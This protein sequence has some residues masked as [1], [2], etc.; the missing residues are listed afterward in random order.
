M[1]SAREPLGLTPRPVM[2]SP[3]TFPTEIWTVI[4]T[5]LCGHCRGLSGADP[6]D[7]YDVEAQTLASLSAASKRLQ[8]VAQPLLFHRLLRGFGKPNHFRHFIRALQL[9][10][11]LAFQIRQVDMSVHPW[12]Y[13]CEDDVAFFK[14]MATQLCLAEESDPGLGRADTEPKIA[15]IVRAEVF[16]SMIPQIE[17]LEVD[18]RKIWGRTPVWGG[19]EFDFTTFLTNRQDETDDIYERLTT[20]RVSSDPDRGFVTCHP[21]IPALL[22]WAPGLETLCISDAVGWD[23][24]CDPA[25]F[26]PRL[27]ML[28]SFEVTNS[29]LATDH[30]EGYLVGLMTQLPDLERFTYWGMPTRCLT[31][32]QTVVDST[33]PVSHS[34]R[35]LDLDSNMMRGDDSGD[36]D[37]PPIA[38]ILHQLTS[39]ETLKIDEASFCRHW[40]QPRFPWT[41]AIVEQSACAVEIVAPSVETFV[42]RVLKESK[43]WEDIVNLGKYVLKGE[44][45]NLR[46]L[47]LLVA[48][49]SHFDEEGMRSPVDEEELISDDLADL[50]LE[51]N[52]ERVMA[53]FE[54]SD[55]EVSIELDPRH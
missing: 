44:F 31:V 33:F 27:D 1:H 19:W 48:Q 23:S 13:H 51:D 22:N 38:P 21:I 26:M 30:D 37:E 3:N 29:M 11:D 24:D 17:E 55:V 32:A 16:L 45:P 4:C 5:H 46:R 28:S 9:R 43:V 53:A 54:G 50:H 40:L 7:D 25:D 49:R 41:Q 35:Y 12:E 8:L 52:R 15:R 14:D 47:T 6:G 36:N 34:L 39:L 20:L 42:V 18:P 2:P 10:P